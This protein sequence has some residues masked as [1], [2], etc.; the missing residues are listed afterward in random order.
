MNS[1]ASAPVE[2]H[3]LIPSQIRSN[4]TSRKARCIISTHCNTVIP[5]TAF[6]VKTSHTYSG[7]SRYTMNLHFSIDSPRHGHIMG[8]SQRNVSGKFL[9]SSYDSSP[10]PPRAA[11]FVEVYLEMEPLFARVLGLVWKQSSSPTYIKRNVSKKISLCLF[12]PFTVWSFVVAKPSLS[13]LMQTL[14]KS[15]PVS[16]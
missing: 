11:V 6:I 2:H 7:S 9:K 16:C 12:K 8:F 10:H 1:G 4:V 13:W 15:Q 14:I 5:H 3:K